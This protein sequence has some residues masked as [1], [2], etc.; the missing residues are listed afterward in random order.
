MPVVNSY[1]TRIHSYMFS[2]K[3]SHKMFSLKINNPYTTVFQGTQCILPH[4][5]PSDIVPGGQ[6][7]SYP[8]IVLLHRKVFGQ[9]NIIVSSHSLMSKS[10]QNIQLAYKMIVQ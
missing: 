6:M 8:P 7:H 9:G 1:I 2:T 4:I 5:I 3:T 10:S